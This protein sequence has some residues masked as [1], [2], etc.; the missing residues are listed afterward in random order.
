M[1]VTGANLRPL[2]SGSPTFT[3]E[4]SPAWSPS[5]DRIAFT[6]TRTI[7]SQVFV[8]DTISGQPVQ[9]SHE[10]G[11]AFAPT[12]S[13]DGRGVLYV[14]LLDQPR[15]MRIPSSGGEPTL[16]ASG[17]RV[18][19]DP[20]CVA[21]LCLAVEGARTEDGD[22]IAMSAGRATAA[23]LVRARNDRNPAFLIP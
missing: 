13:A 19:S 9:L 22:I 15:V 5:G 7:T 8:L 14:A 11:G 12:W 21:F 18:I 4:G 3:P 6:S 23:V 17:D 20:A 1:D 2:E 16:V 10:A